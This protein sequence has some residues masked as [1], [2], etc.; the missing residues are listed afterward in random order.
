MTATLASENGGRRVHSVAYV[1]VADFTYLAAYS[2]SFKTLYKTAV[3]HNRTYYF[4]ARKLPAG[5]KIVGAD[6]K[7]F[8]ARHNFAALVNSDAPVRVAIESKADI[9]T[10]F[11][12]KICKLF[13]MGRTDAVV[14]VCSVGRIA[15]NEGLC[16]KRV[17]NASCNHKRTAVCSVNAYAKPL[18]G[19]G[20]QRY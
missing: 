4:V 19:A 12:D 9:K 17:E 6:I 18:I 13:D 15:Y 20:G 5:F 2:L 8:V 1:F 10:V 3:A 14:Y 16:A 7:L 11:L